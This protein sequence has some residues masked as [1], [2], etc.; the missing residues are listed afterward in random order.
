MTD[1]PDFI[2]SETSAFTEGLLQLQTS[3]YVHRSAVH[4]NVGAFTHTHTHHAYVKFSVLT[5]DPK[6]NLDDVLM[7]GSQACVT[8][9]TKAALA[10]GL[11]RKK[12]LILCSRLCRLGYL[13]CWVSLQALASLNLA[14]DSL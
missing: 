13:P 6:L 14:I 10:M 5:L 12:F 9:S 8:T 7:A 2:A 1:E 11:F 4:T 3:T